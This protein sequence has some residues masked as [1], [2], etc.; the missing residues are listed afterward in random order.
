MSK[1]GLERIELEL[2]AA[3]NIGELHPPSLSLVLQA[4]HESPTL[5][6]FEHVYMLRFRASHVRLSVVLVGFSRPIF[7]GNTYSTKVTP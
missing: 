4:Q 1:A 5:F 6:R 2:L 7:H 3:L